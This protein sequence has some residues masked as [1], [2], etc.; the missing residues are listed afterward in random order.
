MDQSDSSLSDS[1]FLVPK[2]LH[3]QMESL[4][5]QSDAFKRFRRHLDSR[6]ADQVFLQTVDDLALRHEAD[7]IIDAAKSLGS[8]G[9]IGSENPAA[10]KFYVLAMHLANTKDSIQMQTGAETNNDHFNPKL[11]SNY[12]QQRKCWSCRGNYLTNLFGL[13]KCTDHGNNECNGLCG[14]GC[15]CWKF[16]CSDCCLH[17]GCLD[18]DYCCRTSGYRAFAGCYL[19]H[20]LANFRCEQSY[21]CKLRL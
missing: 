12:Q 11:Y 14:R 16:L 17:Q 6:N 8:T 1:I 4:L 20:R 10:M 18:H 5:Q 3:N 15:D 19:P 21:T 7:L 2:A 13:R 9:V